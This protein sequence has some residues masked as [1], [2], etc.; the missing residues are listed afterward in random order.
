MTDWIGWVATGVFAVSYLAKAPETLRRIQALAACLWIGYGVA[1][2]AAPVVVANLVVAAMA[3]VSTFRK[4][5]R[6]AA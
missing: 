1:T 3:I 6:Q 4:T 5:A 2:G